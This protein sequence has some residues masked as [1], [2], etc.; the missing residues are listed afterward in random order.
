MTRFFVFIWPLIVP[1]CAT[2]VGLCSP[3]CSPARLP[4]D[5]L[6][7]TFDESPED[8]S[9]EPATTY[10]PH[11]N[12]P[13][14]LLARLTLPPHCE[15]GIFLGYWVTRRSSVPLLYDFSRYN[16]SIESLPIF[17]DRISRILLIYIYICMYCEFFHAIRRLDRSVWTELYLAFPDEF[18]R[19]LRY[20]GYRATFNLPRNLANYQISLEFCRTSA[21]S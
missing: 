12:S 10:L 13:S 5:P 3:A 11:E 19:I 4:A 9:L 16:S 2:P 17:L 7:R 6:R 15:R 18:F 14:S 20:S 8:S 1:S 21:V